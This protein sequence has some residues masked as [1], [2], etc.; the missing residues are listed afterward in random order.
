MTLGVSNY[1]SGVYGDLYQFM[2]PPVQKMDGSIGT[3]SAVELFPEIFGPELLIKMGIANN[4][5]GS[6]LGM[7]FGNYSNTYSAMWANKLNQPMIT[8]DSEGKATQG[9]SWNEFEYAMRNGRR[10]ESP[11]S[12]GFFG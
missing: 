10:G 3:A 7:D 9:A 5:Q 1:Q 6:G 8:Y 11:S 4:P 12:G 2:P